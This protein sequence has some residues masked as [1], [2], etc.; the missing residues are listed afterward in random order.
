M[1]MNTGIPPPLEFQSFTTGNNNNIS[2][3]QKSSSTTDRLTRDFLGLTGHQHQC[4]SNSNGNGNV[5]VNVHVNMRGMMSSFVGNVDFPTYDRDLSL[6]KHH[7]SFVGGFA[8]PPPT[9]SETW[10]NC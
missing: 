2:T 1:S 8:E 7:G 4:S 5:D 6:L 10:G 3:W 9:A